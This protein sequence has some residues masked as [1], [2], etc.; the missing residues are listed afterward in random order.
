MWGGTFKLDKCS[1]TILHNDAIFFI[2]ELGIL[3]SRLGRKI[4]CGERQCT[5]RDLTFSPWLSFRFW[6]CG[7]RHCVVSQAVNEDSQ[8]PAASTV[9]EE[10]N[11]LVIPHQT[12]RYYSPEDYNLKKWL[13]QLLCIY[14]QRMCENL[15]YKYLLK[16]TL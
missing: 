2:K 9:R 14:L 12:T 10:Q 15:D 1:H 8:E 13:Y 6:S 7:L 5:I 16:Q 3:W 4:F 11:T